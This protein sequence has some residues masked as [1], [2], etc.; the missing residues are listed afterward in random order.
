MK[1]LRSSVG[2]VWLQ[3]LEGGPHFRDAMFGDVV[4]SVHSIN[5]GGAGVTID[6]GTKGTL[7]AAV[8]GGFT[9]PG[10]KT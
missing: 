9:W 3:C 7:E 2:P 6:Q 1:W 5:C 4:E 8:V 10:L